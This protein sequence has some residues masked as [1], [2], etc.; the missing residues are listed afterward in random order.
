MSRV[1]W[2]EVERVL[3]TVM[4]LPESE[5]AARVYELCGE[6]G[7]LRAEVESLLAAHKNAGGFLDIETKLGSELPGSASLAGRQL[8]PYSLLDIIG[9]GGM[10]TVYRAQRTHG[11]FQ[12]QVAIKVVPAAIHS[13]ELQRRFSSEQQILASLEHPNIARLLDAGISPDGVP[14]FVMEYVDGVPVNEYC[15]SHNLRTQERLRLFQTVCESVQYAH[16]HLVVHRDL[17]PANILVS[18][19]GAPKLLDFGVAKILDPW[20]SGFVEATHSLLNP[21][22]PGYASPE[23]AR[24]GSSPRHRTF[25]RSGSCSTNCS[26]DDPLSRSPVNHWTKRFASSRKMSR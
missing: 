9:A 18:G 15:D 5:R 24:G 26:Q 8:G 14:Y 10:G 22:T 16:Q 13:P 3:A 1:D 21:M 2:Q 25:T 19:D 17:K 11:Q 23:Q 6:R 7:E 12:K 20:R 4:E